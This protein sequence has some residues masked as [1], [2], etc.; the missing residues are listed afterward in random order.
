MDAL[1]FTGLLRDLAI[2]VFAAFSGV[3]LLAL[4]VLIFAFYR[5]LAPILEA[6]LRMTKKVEEGAS[7]LNGKLIKPVTGNSNIAYS[8]GRITSFVLGLT[9]RKGRKV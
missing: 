5:K 8:A 6:T 7:A 2:I 3:A 1:E 4:V 9:R